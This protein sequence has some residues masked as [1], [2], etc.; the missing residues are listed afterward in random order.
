MPFD[1][2]I[3]E[4]PKTKPAFHPISPPKPSLE[5]EEVLRQW[6]LDRTLSLETLAADFYTLIDL[7]C[8]YPKETKII[9]PLHRLTNTLA[10]QFS[11]Y[12]DMTIGGELRHAYG[13][14]GEYDEY[15]DEVKPYDSIG[16]M[17]ISDAAKD[18]LRG[19]KG[20][21]MP[22][23]R[24]FVWREWKAVRDKLGTQALH[25]AIETFNLPWGAGYG[26]ESWAN[27]TRV[28]VDYL[29]GELSSLAFVDTCFG[30]HHN[31][32]I[33]LDKVWKVGHELKKVLDLNLD[34]QV[35]SL[36]SYCS[37]QVQNL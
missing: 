24:N 7:Q 30:L 17:P 8:D 19:F 20:L 13:E 11:A 21:S 35:A 18:I 22:S 23:D 36:F 12:L 5:V 14:A 26:G 6:K 2:K 25:C 10:R 27:A 9:I 1:S 4:Q 37:P 16:D 31:N 33:I 32:N 3:K 29:E 15:D 28:L 34:D